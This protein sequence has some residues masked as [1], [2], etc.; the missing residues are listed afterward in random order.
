MALRGLPPHVRSRHAKPF[1]PRGLHPVDLGTVE[2]GVILLLLGICGVIA[3]GIANSKN[4]SP[5]SPASSVAAVSALALA[6]II[7]APTASADVS[8]YLQ[9][10]EQ[11]GIHYSY[12]TRNAAIQMGVAVCDDFRRGDD[13]LAVMTNTANRTARIESALLVTLTAAKNL[14]PEY[15]GNAIRTAFDNGWLVAGRR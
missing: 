5:V 13:L 12:D 4:R 2:P 15:Y 11:N 7:R 1:A 8:N 9:E 14:C 3:S 6:V 10:L